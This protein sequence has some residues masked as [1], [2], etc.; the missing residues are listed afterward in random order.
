MT[1]TVS[2][3]IPYS[4]YASH[5]QREHEKKSKKNDDHPHEY[6]GYT[7][8]VERNINSIRNALEARGVKGK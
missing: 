6:L 8:P 5:E 2:D 7:C 3:K 4:V 1:E